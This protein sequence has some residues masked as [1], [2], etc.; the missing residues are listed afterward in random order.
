MVDADGGSRFE[1]LEALWKEM[2]RIAPKDEAAVV[3]GSRAHLVKTEAVIKASTNFT[4]PKMITTKRYLTVLYP[5]F[6]D[7]SFSMS[8]CMTYT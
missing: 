7:H 1:D 4:N 5:F 6:S 8:S 3:V 2:D